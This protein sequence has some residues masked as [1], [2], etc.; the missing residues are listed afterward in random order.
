MGI[1]TASSVKEIKTLDTVF[2]YNGF[3]DIEEL[4][5]TIIIDSRY[6]TTNNFAGKVFHPFPLAL[7][8][9]EVAE[10]LLEAQEVA[11]D[12][13]YKIRIYDAYRPL[14]V[15]RQ[16]FEANTSSAS[17]FVAK[18]GPT[19]PHPSGLA[20]DVGLS[21]YNDEEVE[22][23]SLY[24]D[25]SER[26]YADY[27]GGTPEQTA[28]RK[29]L[30]QIMEGC[31]FTV[32]SKEWWHFTAPNP[33]NY[34]AIDMSFEEFVE[35]REEYYASVPTPTPPP[36]IRNFD[37][38]FVYN[39]LVDIRELDPRII[40][41]LRYAT[42]NNFASKVFHPFPLAL[43]RVETAKMF[44][45]AQNLAWS[46]GYRLRIYDSYRPLLVQRQLFEANASG[47]A[48]FVAAPSENE[49][50]S[51]G[52]AID[53]GLS[54]MDGEEVEMPS[55][56]NEFTQRAYA[57]YSGGSV[58]ATANR[59][60]LKRIMTEVGFSVYSK[61]WWHYNAPN[62]QRLKALDMPFQEFVDKRAEYYAG[63]EG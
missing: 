39:G 43:M 41:D 25:L 22:M 23:P 10:M 35:K 18:P 51:I 42:T 27:A 28:N 57:T 24:N 63:L 4:D 59:E 13:G 20:L 32:Y 40:I 30:R 19:A 49:K 61:E 16:L 33:K 8:R 54:Y 11:L 12:L 2:T 29:M 56:Y 1:L 3:L 31:G 58:E 9:K 17:L 36:A 45:K 6:A 62:P 5:P 34:T 7:V 37:T 55:P 60:L 26:A 38:I 21:Y 52:L 46:Q 53:C 48:L 14:F 15:Q 47:S 50:H 44:I